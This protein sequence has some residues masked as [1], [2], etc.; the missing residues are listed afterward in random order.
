MITGA[1]VSTGSGIPDY[2]GPDSPARTPMTY[3]QF[4]ADADYRRHYWARNHLGWR[5][6][7][8]ARPN[9]AH[10][11]LAGWERR[12]LLAGRAATVSLP[13]G[14]LEVEWGANGRIT[15]AGPAAESFRGSFDWG[16]FA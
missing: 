8:A 11:V 7:E 10:R 13:G 2:R 6:M 3:Q 4:I 15:M 5:H 12:G 9:T 16:D 14:P 1:G